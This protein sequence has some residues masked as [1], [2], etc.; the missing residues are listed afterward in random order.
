MSFKINYFRTFRQF[1]VEYYREETRNMSTTIVNKPSL[2]ESDGLRFLVMDAPKD[3]N[4]HLYIAECRKY[5]VKHIVRISEP[6]YSKEA[7]E[8]A[9]ISVHVRFR[10]IHISLLWMNN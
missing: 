2:I 6:S 5:N 10:Y 3:T 1:I 8:S 4:L 7:V 9:G